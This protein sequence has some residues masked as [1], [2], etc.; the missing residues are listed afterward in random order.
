MK[1]V[2]FLIIFFS[3]SFANLQAQR[4]V[5]VDTDY[6]L[7]NMPEYAEAQEKL[8]TFVAAWNEDIIKK[9]QA[10]IDMKATFKQN[11][12]LMPE[13][14]KIEE[15]QKIAKAESDLAK[16]KLRRFGTKGDLYKKQQDL[17]KPI[18]DRVYNAIK[19]MSEYRDY[20][21]VLDKATGVSILFVKPKLDVSDEVL[22]IVNVKKDK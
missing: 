11:E 2:L 17:I 6:I 3:A 7:E 9:E 15:E 19:Q 18:Q 22:R 1:K 14:T 5:Y 13:V 8:E 21:M 4:I 12:L 20:D 10:V 16:L